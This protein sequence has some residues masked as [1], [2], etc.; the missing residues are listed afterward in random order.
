MPAPAEPLLPAASPELCEAGV[1]PF[2]VI[3]PASL[4]MSLPPTDLQL[5]PDGRILVL[6]RHEIAVGDGVR[7]ERFRAAAP[8]VALGG[9]S[10]AVAADGSIYT[11]VPG[12]FARV[13]FVGS[14]RWR[15]EPVAKLP[16]DPALENAA[17]RHVV[18]VP[19]GWFW[20]GNSGPTVAWQPGTAAVVAARVGVEERPFVVGG[21]LH[22][23][24]QSTG[25]L[26]RATATAGGSEPVPG[27]AP[28]DQIVTATVPL[29]DGQVLA[30]TLGAGVGVFDGRSLTPWPVGGTLLRGH[31]INALCAVG[32]DRYAAAVDA[33]GIVFFDGEGRLLQ[34]LDSDQDRRLSRVR[35]L[36]QAPSGL[37][38]ALLDDGL[39][40]VGFPAVVSDYAALAGRSLTYAR[41]VRHEGRLWMLAD[42]RV[43][44]GVYG[45]AGRIERFE[46][47]S[48]SAARV[49]NFQEA[50]GAL[51]ATDENAIYRRGAAGWS[52]VATGIVDARFA[53][54]R[55]GARGLPYVARDEIG[56]LR[57]TGEEVVPERFLR[58]GLGDTYAVVTAP[59]G[60][61]WL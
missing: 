39:A 6:S 8:E 57:S 16:A 49:F 21:R 41:P 24:D 15:L 27:P 19:E 37:L 29:R 50:D 28:V 52:R 35:R 13:V 46:D 56:W 47:D 40:R 7:W 17:L 45:A 53:A 12:G 20:Y 34:V 42:G 23:V 61:L 60:A 3:S 55:S 38:W 4:E 54:D 26:M 2:A 14:D 11:T 48:P 1:P 18:T 58:P 22:L 43:L 30:G 25:Q 5:L 10:V 51:W 36:L 31:R 59:D 44:R 33:L 32:E 9:D